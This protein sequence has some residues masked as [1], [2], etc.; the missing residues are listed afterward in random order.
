[1]TA[2]QPLMPYAGTAIALYLDS[3]ALLGSTISGCCGGATLPS[4][5]QTTGIEFDDI[6]NRNHC[7]VQARSSCQA[8]DC[9]PAK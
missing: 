2:A 6:L 1:M 7:A 3:K 5:I 4:V 9:D 8:A